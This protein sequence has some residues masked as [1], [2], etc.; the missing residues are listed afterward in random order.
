MG[1]EENQRY[2]ER[3]NMTRNEF[4]DYKEWKKLRVVIYVIAMIGSTILNDRINAWVT[5]TVIIW[6]KQKH[7]SKCEAQW[8][9]DGAIKKEDLL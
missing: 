3:F 6:L 5:F 1:E 9:K 4:Q 2:C 7:E 8:I